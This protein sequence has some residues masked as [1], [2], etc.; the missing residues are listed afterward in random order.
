MVAW[1]NSVCYY[2]NSANVTPDGTYFKG[3][4]VI[5]ERLVESKIKTSANSKI[6]DPKDI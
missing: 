1:H 2:A 6:R 3:R 4:D 5:F